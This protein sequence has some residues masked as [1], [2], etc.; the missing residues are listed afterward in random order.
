MAS[1]RLV[2][3]KLG[4]NKWV[5]DED[6]FHINV[7]RSQSNVLHPACFIAFLGPYMWW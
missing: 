2:E 5:V 3:K 4:Q 1:M 6:H 7:P